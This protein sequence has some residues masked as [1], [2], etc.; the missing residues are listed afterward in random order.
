MFIKQSRI[1]TDKYFLSVP[2]NTHIFI[3]VND[4]TRFPNQLKAFGFNET[5]DSGTCILPSI[6]NRYA[7]KNAEPYYII[8]KKLPKENYTQTL[9]WTRQEWA[10]R[11]EKREVTEFVDITRKRYHRDYYDPFS[12]CFTYIAGKEPCIVSD[13][14]LNTSENIEKLMNTVNMLLGLFGECSVEYENMPRE[15]KHVQ[16]NWDVLPPGKYPWDRVK[17]SLDSICVKSNKTQVAMMMR[18][19]ESIYKVGPSF[20]AY[21]RSGFRGYVVF[22]FPEKSTYI[23]ESIYPNNATYVFD[24]DWEYLSKLTKAEILSNNLHRTRII[25]TKNW[26]QDFNTV[27]EGSI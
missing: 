3:K 1:C 13:S 21:G 6:F 19:C 14:I 23:L 15:I 16:L 8:N 9:Y 12:V 10:G 20:V 18:N 2:I 26:E 25:H 7:A 24:S 27:M 22:G 17:S 4:I 5:D 11:G